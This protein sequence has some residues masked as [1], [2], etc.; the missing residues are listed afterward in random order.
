MSIS[1]CQCHYLS[2]TAVSSCFKFSPFSLLWALWCPSPRSPSRSERLFP[3]PLPLPV[4]GSA[5][6]RQ[7]S[8]HSPL[9]E[10]LLLKKNASPKVMSPSRGWL[11]SGGVDRSHP[12]TPS[13]D[14]CEVLSQ[15]QN[16][17]W[18]WLRTG[19]QLKFSLCPI[20]LPFSLFRKYWF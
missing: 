13:W 14:N 12:L 9:W 17:P 1:I 11:I 5:I 19:S 4:P 18:G 8:A 20:L 7:L 15:P 6:G 16:S 10:M 3:Y 2:V